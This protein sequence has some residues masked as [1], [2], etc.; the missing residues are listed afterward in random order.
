MKV[1]VIVHDPAVTVMVTGLGGPAFL[2]GG[3]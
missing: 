3:H 1:A 2:V